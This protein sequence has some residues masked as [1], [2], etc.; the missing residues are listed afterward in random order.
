MFGQFIDT[1][2]YLW[3]TFVPTDL[4]GTASENKCKYCKVVAETTHNI[5]ANEL[6][7]YAITDALV[8]IC[9]DILPMFGMKSDNCKGVIDQ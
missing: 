5:L 8:V 1:T 4:V 9:K 7:Y 3:D 2:D 6:V